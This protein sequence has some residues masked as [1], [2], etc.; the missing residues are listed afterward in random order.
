MIQQLGSLAKYFSSGICTVNFVFL[1][2]STFTTLIL[3]SASALVTSRNYFGD[4]IECVSD[5]TFPAKLIDS[6]CLRSSTYSKG[7]FIWFYE[8]APVY[9]GL[10]DRP[11][12]EQEKHYH[13]YYQY[14][15]L[16]LFL[17]GLSFYIPKLIWNS[18]ERGMI[19]D[20]VYA[21]NQ[22]VVPQNDIAGNINH[23][24]Q[25][26]FLKRFSYKDLL[27]TYCATEILNFLLALFHFF[28]TNW[29]LS[30]QFIWY[31]WNCIQFWI[32]GSGIQPETLFPDLAHCDFFEYASDS[33]L[34]LKPCLCMLS[35]NSFNK[36][37]FFALWFWYIFIILANVVG[38]TYRALTLLLP[39][40]HFVAFDYKS[41][42]KRAFAGTSHAHWFIV[43]RIC[44]NIRDTA[45]TQDLIL[46][47]KEIVEIEKFD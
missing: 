24:A 35:Q 9:P 44:S 33:A 27:Y 2:H 4:F 46:T 25:R 1:L 28:S 11:E 3:I 45:T 8:N 15:G 30:N 32:T 39:M 34:L 5:S 47:M 36:M 40:T 12:G 23:V 18:V 19:Y 13:Y 7:N 43:K 42:V 14:V 20:Y 37:L 6:F 10:N 38:L 31:G 16:V 22:P 41:D 17:Q 26:L 21:L 29:F